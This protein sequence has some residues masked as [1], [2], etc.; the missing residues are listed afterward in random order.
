MTIVRNARS[1]ALLAER[2]EVAKGVVGRGLG[3]MGRP[4]WRR[5]DALL[6]PHCNSV[7]SFF[8]LF[9]I[10]L[11]YLDKEGRVVRTRSA[12]RPWRVG[13][14]D[15]RADAVL[16]LPAGTLERSQTVVGDTIR[17]EGG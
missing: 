3:L 16:E 11:A 15:F 17:I 9:P 4:D 1:G 2:A 10:D 12:L 14:I 7:H 6:L 13:P 8:M 5:S